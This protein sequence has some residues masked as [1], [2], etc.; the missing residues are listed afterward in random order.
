MPVDANV[1]AGAF[2]FSLLVAGV[3]P[4]GDYAQVFPAVIQRIVIDV[5]DWPFG[6]LRPCDHPVH[7]NLG[8]S[9]TLTRGLPDGIE[10]PNAGAPHGTP[11]ES[12]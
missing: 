12:A 8:L 5:V 4:S 6:V 9:T 1:L 7:V 3:L 11:T 10:A 2:W